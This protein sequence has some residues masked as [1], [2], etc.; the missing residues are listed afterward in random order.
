MSFRYQK[1]LVAAAL[2]LA[3]GGCA[4][5]QTATPPPAAPARPQMSPATMIHAIRT[6][7]EREKSA[8]DV[9]PLADPGVAGLQRA[10]QADEQ[11]GRYPA[12]AAEL[13][14][15]IRLSPQSP[16]LLQDR[17]EVA[18]WLKDY[19]RAEQL[20]R[21]SWQLGPRLGPLCA[22]NQQT[23]V[24]LRIQAGDE[25]GAARARAAVKQCHVKGVQR[26]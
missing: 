3:V 11:A 25:A 24:E 9:N 12:A 13:D 21:Q 8:I 16:D 26:F 10:A 23:L 6:A 20:A 19:T 18:I 14:R 5:F 17:A 15:A 22:R 7:G 1:S 4:L 2:A